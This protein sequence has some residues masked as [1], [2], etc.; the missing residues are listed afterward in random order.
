MDCATILASLH[1]CA[2]P[3]ICLDREPERTEFVNQ[4]LYKGLN[5]LFV[6]VLVPMAI[7]F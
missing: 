1:F 4:E 5:L 7:G 3:V 6:D 2:N